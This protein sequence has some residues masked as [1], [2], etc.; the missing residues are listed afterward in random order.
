MTDELELQ[1]LNQYAPNKERLAIRIAALKIIKKTIFCALKGIYVTIAEYGSLPLKTFLPEGDIDLTVVVPEYQ[2]VNITEFILERVKAQFEYI[3]ILHPEYSI[4]DLL[5][6][7]A[8][9]RLIKLRV[10]GIPVDISVNQL[11]GV[12]TLC[13][14]E[15]ID[16]LFPDH[17]FKRCIIIA[18]VWAYYESRVLGSM[19]GLLSTYALEILVLYIINCFPE[20]RTSPLHVLTTMINVLAEHDWENE[21]I[22]CCGSMS[23]SKYV[24]ALQNC[25]H[26]E[27]KVDKSLKHPILSLV[28]LQNL[29]SEI[30][31]NEGFI[32]PQL[33][34]MNIIDPLD[35]ANNL[36]KSVSVANFSKIQIAFKAASEVVKVYGVSSLFSKQFYKIHKIDAIVNEGSFEEDSNSYSDNNPNKEYL[37]S[38][39]ANIFRLKENLT[40]CK[41]ILDPVYGTAYHF[42]NSGF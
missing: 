13:F 22:T 32:Y 4:S 41:S 3:S 14:L 35:S 34:L 12:R 23:A 29:Q 18:K 42:V 31:T 10:C 15:E 25:E 38:L 24:L 39:S 2:G 5:E 6:I 28:L 27:H 21:I 30:G 33:K 17:F 8:K 9:I 20:S 19:Q 16:R 36:G 11:G 1:L 37:P 40:L 26:P 7:N